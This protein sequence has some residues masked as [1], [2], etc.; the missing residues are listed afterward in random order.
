ML[1]NSSDSSGKIALFASPLGGHQDAH[2][3][4]V[5]RKNAVEGACP[6]DFLSNVWRISGGTVDG[7]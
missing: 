3:E 2:Q 1:R 4:T 7:N 6:F 5:T